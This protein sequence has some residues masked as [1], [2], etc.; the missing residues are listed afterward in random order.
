MQ[1]IAVAPSFKHP[2]NLITEDFMELYC[3]MA[4]EFFTFL[5][6]FLSHV[7]RIYPFPTRHNS[8][9]TRTAYLQMKTNPSPHTLRLQLQWI[10]NIVVFVAVLRSAVWN[11]FIS[12]AQVLASRFA[13]YS[14][15]CR[16]LIRQEI[17]R[18]LWQFSEMLRSVWRQSSHHDGIGGAS[19]YTITVLRQD[20]GGMDGKR[21][22]IGLSLRLLGSLN[23]SL[24]VLD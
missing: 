15:V 17:N 10:W 24:F 13:A 5:S 23:G 4:S 7:D 3:N 6:L 19:R 18:C 12:L 11:M 8:N 22:T 16:Y 9:N 1:N 14:V 2:A 20:Y 21:Y